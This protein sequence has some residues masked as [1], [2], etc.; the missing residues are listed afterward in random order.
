ME[1]LIMLLAFA[2]CFMG[3][4]LVMGLSITNIEI[5][6]EAKFNAEKNAQYLDFGSDGRDIR[7]WIYT[8]Y[9]AINDY[10][11]FLPKDSPGGLQ[12]ALNSFNFEFNNHHYSTSN[13]KYTFN[14]FSVIQPST[15]N[16]FAFDT[17]SFSYQAANL[18]MGKAYNVGKEQ[19][20]LLTD[21]RYFDR[22]KTYEAFE[23]LIG[24]KLK[25]IDLENYVTMILAMQDGILALKVLDDGIDDEEKYKN[26][27]K[28]MWRDISTENMEKNRDGGVTSA[29]S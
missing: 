27:Q 2:I 11:P 28:Q 18:L 29:V 23:L 9:E 15:A 8:F 14:D 19:N 1:L 26:I 25:D 4:L 24:T 20:A 17:P 7:R 3:L 6:T 21:H 22:Q 5:F 10:I 16:N 13:D 12:T